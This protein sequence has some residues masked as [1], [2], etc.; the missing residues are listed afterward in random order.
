[1]FTFSASSPRDCSAPAFSFPREPGIQDVQEV[2]HTDQD[3]AK[4]QKKEQ[5]HDGGD[6]TFQIIISIEKDSLANFD[7]DACFVASV[8][9]FAT[10]GFVANHAFSE[11]Q[12]IGTSACYGLATTCHGWL[13]KADKYSATFARK[14]LLGRI[15]APFVLS[16]LA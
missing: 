15:L 4:K 8:L 11:R 16:Y 1:M 13:Y 10:D 14:G 7:E 12:K 5:F 6:R 3:E 9:S 2:E